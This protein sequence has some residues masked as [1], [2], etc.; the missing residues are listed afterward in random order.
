MPGY[1]SWKTLYAAEL[2]Q[3]AEEGYPVDI[4]LGW[5]E[6]QPLPLPAGVRAESDG[7]SDEA[8]WERAYHALWRVR[9]RGL[10]PDYPYREPDDLAGILAAA[11]EVPELVPL[12]ESG[13]ADRVRGAWSGR[14]AGCVLGKPLEMGFDRTQIHEYLASVDAYPLDDWVPIRSEPLDRTLRLDCLPS[15]RGHVAYVQPD[16]DIHYTIMSL[17][18]VEQ[19]GMDFTKADVGTSLLDN[20]PY[21]WLWAAHKQAYYH[22][23][24]LRDDRPV[25]EQIDEIPLK[26]NPWRESIDGQLKG[27]LWGYIFPG[28]PRAAAPLIHRQAS[29]CLTKNGLYG[30]MFVAGCVAAALSVQP[31]VAT[32][33]AGGLAVIPRES[34]LA[35]MVRLVTGWYAET[36][37]WVATCQRIEARYGHLY[38]AA[39]VNNL[40]M[41]VL[42]LLHGQLDFT[43]SITTAVMAGNDVD[44]NGATVGSIVGAAIGYDRL[45]RRWVDPLNDTVRTVVA[46]FGDGSISDLTQRTLAL[47]RR[48][49]PVTPGHP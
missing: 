29:L 33:L 16:D 11:D 32:I 26:L 28:E 38:Y 36:A 4:P 41:V 34:R 15:S 45:D 31:S 22:L 47:R 40:A 8:G 2:A 37:D 27:D 35:E 3:L 9:E 1:A 19:K 46:G 6:S 20:V 23:V 30:G 14:C 10:R 17:L 13:L 7:S 43:R 42:A 21:N 12:A 44:C 18:L 24:N 49:A 25:S 5:V 48:D 39:T